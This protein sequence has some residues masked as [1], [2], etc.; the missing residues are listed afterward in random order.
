MMSVTRVRIMLSGGPAGLSA[1]DRDV[2]VAELGQP[3]KICYRAGY[4]HF[5]HDGEFRTVDEREVAVFR[6]TYRTKI[7]E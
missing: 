6:W 7:A 3:L 5:V 1:A 2:P 4:E